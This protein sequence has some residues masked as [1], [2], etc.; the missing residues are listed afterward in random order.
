M[1]LLRAA[2]SSLAPGM[3]SSRRSLALLRD[4]RRALAVQ[5]LARGDHSVKQIAQALGFSS[6]GCFHRAFRR[7]LGATPRE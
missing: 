2:S 7:W 1:R 5:L 6:P 4:S 3:R